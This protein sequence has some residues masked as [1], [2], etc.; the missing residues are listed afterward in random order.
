MA[1][2]SIQHDLIIT[3]LGLARRL[4]RGFRGRGV[5]DDDLEQVAN[6]AL[7][8]AAAGFDESRGAFA[9]F[10]T[11]TIRGEIKRHFR[12]RAWGVRPPRR[13]QELQAQLSAEHSGD[14]TSANVTQLADRLGADPKDVKEAAAA[15]GCYSPDSLDLALEAGHERGEVDGRLEQVDEWVTFCAA[16]KGLSAQE[17]QLLQWRF[18]EDRTQQDIA[19]RL[20][21]SQMQVSRR[22]S[23]LLTGLREAVGGAEAA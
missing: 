18:V 10:A 9:A 12:D 4:A 20:H 23:S 15:R 5:E 2:T 22:L 16:S 8:K 1:A 14:V 7:V 21:I 11:A 13:L 6:L 3:H 19:D 17:R